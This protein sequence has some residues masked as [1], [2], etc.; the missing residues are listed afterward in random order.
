LRVTTQKIK[1]IGFKVNLSSNV[2]SIHDNRSKWI[3]TTSLSKI[4]ARLAI[5]DKV[6]NDAYTLRHDSYASAG[7]IE[8]QE[9][10]V[11]QDHFDSLPSSKTIVLYKNGVAAASARVCLL[12]LTG[13][14]PGATTIPSS[15][16]FGEEITKL[17][18]GMNR[19]NR[20]ACAVEVTKLAR[21]P[22]FLKDN[23]LVFGMFRMAGYLI[24]HF[25]A[26]AVLT[27]VRAN[28]IPFYRRLG[29]QEVAEPRPYP[30]L[31][32]IKG[33]LIACFRSSFEGVQHNVPVM[34][35]LSSDDGIY[36][37]FMDGELVP[38]FP[39]QYSC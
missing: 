24:L 16:I 9:C 27:A 21:H 37:R 39:E 28:H 7:F 32:N 34:N 13:K 25:E 20:P 14:T 29:F 18:C 33:G 8:T 26:D 1:D 23:N 36:S 5:T 15:K 38:V 17:L 4:E 2:V 30:G 31:N 10:G 35:A 6:K 3:K 11:L 12:D 19:G 22:N